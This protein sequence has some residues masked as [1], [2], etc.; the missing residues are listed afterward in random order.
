V[1]DVRVEGEKDIAE[2]TQRSVAQVRREV[3]SYPDPLPAWKL[4]GAK[5]RLWGLRSRLAAWAQRHPADGAPVSG[6]LAVVEGGEAIGRVVR[7]RPGR[8]WLFLPW[9]QPGKLLLDP[10]PV[11]RGDDGSLRAYREALHDWLDR[12]SEHAG[13]GKAPTARRWKSR[14]VTAKKRTSGKTAPRETRSAA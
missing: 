14:L 8:L 13:A 10:L 12:R 6:E 7:I 11:W 5:G 2:V 3:A 9:T 1:A 4:R